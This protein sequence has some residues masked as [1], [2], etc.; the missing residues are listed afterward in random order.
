M[1]NEKFAAPAA[2]TQLWRSKMGNLYLDQFMSKFE[3]EG[4]TFDDISLL[5]Q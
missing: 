1:A 3:F 2:H 4:L 5:T